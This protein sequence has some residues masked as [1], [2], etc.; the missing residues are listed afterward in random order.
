MSEPKDWAADVGSLVAGLG[1]N[2]LGVAARVI[3][4]AVGAE[5]FEILAL[6]VMAMAFV[7]TSMAA[8]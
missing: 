2:L 5:P 3:H 7:L 1:K 4:A 6:E 8:S